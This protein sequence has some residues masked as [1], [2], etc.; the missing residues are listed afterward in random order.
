MRQKIDVVRPHQQTDKHTVKYRSTLKGGKLELM[1]GTL[2]F[3]YFDSE[4]R[5]GKQEKDGQTT[6]RS[7]NIVHHLFMRK[8]LLQ[9]LS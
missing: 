3:I 2:E 5:S 1:Y 6:H 7:K 4:V 9:L 8:R